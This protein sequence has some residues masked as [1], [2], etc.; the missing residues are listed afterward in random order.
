M[1]AQTAAPSRRQIG[2]GLAA[3]SLAWQESCATIPPAKDP[4]HVVM[5]F[6]NNGP[7]PAGARPPADS[8]RASIIRTSVDANLRM[9]APVLLDGKG[10]YS[11][12]VDTGANVSVLST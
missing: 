10:P 8:D 5:D 1:R 3:A 12:V 4:A 7:P 11:F 9:T 2:L 6:A